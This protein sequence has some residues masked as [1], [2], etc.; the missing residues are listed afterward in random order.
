MDFIALRAEP[1]HRLEILAAAFRRSSTAT[2]A[3]R[4]IPFSHQRH[5]AFLL[6]MLGFTLDPRHRLFHPKRCNVFD[7]PRVDLRVA[8]L[9]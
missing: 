8:K 5:P 9:A 4:N 6:P 1:E 3:F 2:F 7:H